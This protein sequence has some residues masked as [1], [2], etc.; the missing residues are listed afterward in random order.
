VDKLK[1]V[2]KSQFFSIVRKFYENRHTPS[3]YVRLS[4]LFDFL[5]FEQLNIWSIFENEGS[6]FWLSEN[7]RFSLFSERFLKGVPK[8]RSFGGTISNLNFKILSMRLTEM[9]RKAEILAFLH[10]TCLG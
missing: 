3:F 5:T 4:M 9:T 6:M 10:L 2:K 8:N 7:L 1:E